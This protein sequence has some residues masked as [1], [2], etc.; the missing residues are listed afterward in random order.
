MEMEMHRSSGIKRVR[1]TKEKD[2]DGAVRGS[3]RQTKME[4]E[5]IRGNRRAGR[6]R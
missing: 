1:E 4:G 5:K 2:R 3:E 6:K